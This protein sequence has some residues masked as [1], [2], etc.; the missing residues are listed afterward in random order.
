[1]ILILSSGLF[2][3]CKTP[4]ISQSPEIKPSLNIICYTLDGVRDQGANVTIDGVAYITSN[5]EVT[6]KNLTKGSHSVDYEDPD[7]YSQWLIVRNSL[8]GENIQQK[9]VID[10]DSNV[11]VTSDTTLYLLKIPKGWD[12]NQVANY[13]DDGSGLYKIRASTIPVVEYDEYNGDLTEARRILDSN[14]NQSNSAQ[15]RGEFTIERQKFVKQSSAS[16]PKI[17]VHFQDINSL[18]ASHGE[19]LSGNEITNTLLKLP[20]DKKYTY[21]IITTHEWF[22]GMTHTGNDDLIKYLLASDGY[23]ETYTDLANKVIMNY[24]NFDPG[25]RFSDTA[26]VASAQSRVTKMNKNI[27]KMTQPSEQTPSPSFDTKGEINILPRWDT[28]LFSGKS[29]HNNIQELPNNK[30]G[31][32]IRNLSIK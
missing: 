24:V 12:M 27:I 26:Y 15:K 7:V 21:P 11:P 28:I 18:S 22:Q 10:T 13:L 5:A 29:S 17:E 6:V 3:S 30:K 9:D 19:L 2:I 23:S 20:G 16:D 25:T 32:K 8:N 1:M 4:T 31:N 14:I